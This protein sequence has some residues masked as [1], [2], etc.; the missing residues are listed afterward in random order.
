[1]MEVNRQGMIKAV[2]LG[3]LFAVFMPLFPYMKLFLIIS[4]FLGGALTAYYYYNKCG[5]PGTK[6][7]V[8]MGLITG[9]L[10][11]LFICGVLALQLSSI[12]DAQIKEM[13]E[14]AYQ[15]NASMLS[16]LEP[17]DVKRFEAIVEG[18]RSTFLPLAYKGIFM[19]FIYFICSSVVGSLAALFYFRKGEN[20]VVKE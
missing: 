1:M 10:G 20:N 18:G 4:F 13:L 17:E 5:D 16:M 15:Q 6:K 3:V 8:T 9:T 2:M 19:F 12:P 14:H 7:I 11:G